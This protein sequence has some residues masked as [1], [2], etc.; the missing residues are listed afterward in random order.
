VDYIKALAIFYFALAVAL[1]ATL[2][3]W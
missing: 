1:F 2:L 3:P